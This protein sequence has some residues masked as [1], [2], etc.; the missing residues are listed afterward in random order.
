MHSARTYW[1][2]SGDTLSQTTSVPAPVGLSLAE[3]THSARN[4]YSV[5]D[6]VDLAT[7]VVRE[8][9][10]GTPMLAKEPGSIC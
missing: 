4:G 3:R 5:M 7:Q 2:L 1:S 6:I 8:H 10:L 9:L